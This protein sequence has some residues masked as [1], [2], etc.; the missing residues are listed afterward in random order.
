MN[1]PN[2]PA[3][4]VSGA[5]LEARMRSTPYQAYSYSYPHK[6]AYRPLAAPQALAE[7]WAQQDRSALFAYVHIP[8]CAMRCGFCNLFAMARPDAALVQAYVDQ[9]LLQMRVMD[10]VLGQRRFAR[11]AMGGG[12]PT[13]LSAPQ[14]AQLLAG[15]QNLLGIDLAH[16]PAGIEASPETVT[17]EKM[18]VC[19]EFGLARVSLGVQSF[20]ALEVRAL[21]RPQQNATVRAA[22][23]QIRAAQIPTLNLDLIY[24]MAGQTC[25][26][27]IASIDSALEFAPEEIYLYPLYVREQTGLG[28]IARRKGTSRLDTLRLQADGDSRL[29]LYECARDHLRARGYTQVSMRMFRAPHAPV[30]DG[31][32]Y[33]CQ[34]D[35]MLGFGAG[36]RSYAGALHYSSEYAVA[37]TQTQEIIQD[38]LAC[39]AAAFALAG[40][41]F[42]LSRQEQQRRFVIQ[43]LLAEPGLELAAYRQRFGSDCL[44]DLPQL[45]QLAELGLTQAQAGW[46]HLN[47]TGYAWADT[48]G[49]WLASEQV[50]ALMDETRGAQQHG[51]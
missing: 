34:N 18:A 21:A 35:G 37:R 32:A 29:A 49:P 23:E 30:Q 15:A 6:A 42:V 48:I 24:G 5:T 22:I 9:V 31:P 13:Y 2:F 3:A 38:Y 19:R 40:Y 44:E 14:L 1:H 20:S 33:C 7:L 12:T 16:T 25:A 26:S 4:L 43:S 10:E 8:F 47:D 17:P 46:L 28:K 41:G 36:A 27:L 45:Q 51:E 39:D 11:F 50:Q